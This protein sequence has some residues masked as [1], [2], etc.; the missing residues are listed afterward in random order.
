MLSQA[1]TL[2]ERKP[3]LRDLELLAV[4]QHQSGVRL[5]VRVM[6]RLRQQDNAYA[7]IRSA[8]SGAAATAPVIKEQIAREG[9]TSFDYRQRMARKETGRP[10][11]NR[12]RWMR[13]AVN[14]MGTMTL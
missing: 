8:L 3:T 5:Y 6:T 14:E 1:R 11:P 9:I 2:A 7:T 4:S 13:A 10:R 12:A